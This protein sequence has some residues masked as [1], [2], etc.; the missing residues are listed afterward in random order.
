MTDKEAAIQQIAN[1]NNGIVT[2]TQ[3]TEAGIPRRCLSAMVESGAIHR[4]ERGIYTLPDNWED[5]MYFMQHRFSKGIYSH[6]TA[7]YLHNMIDRTPIRYT[8][9]FPFGYNT[10]SVKKQGIIAKLSTEETYEL[11]IITMPSPSGNSVK[12]YDIERTLCDIVKARHRADIQVINQAMKAYAS[13]KNKD[14]EK[15][16]NYANRF[17]V[18][19]K[20]LKYM[21]VLL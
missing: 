1:N 13:S 18:K 3:V 10:G 11:G 21:E 6:E 8:M 2:A 9:T 16:M 14:I 4:V 12:V 15:L 20:I 5:E 17:R 7:L 19:L